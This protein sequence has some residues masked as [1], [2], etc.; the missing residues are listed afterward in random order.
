MSISYLIKHNTAAPA[1]L[2]ASGIGVALLTIKANGLDT[3]ALTVNS[4]S[5]GGAAAFAFG[6]TIAVLKRS[7][8]YP[9]TAD[10]CI[11]VGTVEEIPRQAIGGAEQTLSYVVYGPTYA[12]QR[13]HFSQQWTYRTAEGVSTKAYE[14]TVCLGE[15]NA[16][17][18]IASGPQIEQAIDYAIAVGVPIL[19]GTIAAGVTVPFDERQ[20]ITCWDAIVSML[21][22]TPD[23]VFTWDYNTTDGGVYTPSATLSAPASMS[24]VTKAVTSLS[25]GSLVPRYDIQV[26][27]ITIIFNYTDTIDGVTSKTRVTQ[28]AGTTD[29]PRSL[30]LAYDLEGYNITYLKQDVEVEDYPADWTAAAG[31]TWLKAQ[32]PWLATLADGDWTVTSCTG[33]GASGHPARL[34]S[35]SVADWM[36]VDQEPE[37]FT[38]LISYTKKDDSSGVVEQA[39]KKV[40]FQCISTDAVTKTYR[41]QGDFLGPEPV[42][43]DLASSLYTSWS[44]LHWDGSISYREQTCSADL[45]PGMLLRISGSLAAWASMDA[46]VQDTTLDLYTGT[47]SVRCGTCDRLEADNLMAIFRAARG[48]SFCFRRESR[49]EPDSSSGDI[50]GTGST[51]K[52][53]TTDGSPAERINRLRIVAQDVNADTQTIDL[54]PAAVLFEA[55]ADQAAQTIAPRERV[56]PYMDEGVLKSK[57]AQ[58]LCSEGYGA[59]IPVAGTRPADPSSP[60]TRGANTETDFTSSAAYNPLSPGAGEDGLSL[61]VSMGCFYDHTASPPL[62]KE[63]RVKLTFPNAICPAV[64]AAAAI[65]IEAPELES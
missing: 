25:S 2:A 32:V 36:S 21:R 31:K 26:P 6:D 56:V 48:R 16:G 63:F 61:W 15:S 18:R 1:T 7:S 47:T 52:S 11:F 45:L 42:P 55:E 41:K 29:N 20:N 51:P 65:T 54:Y 43:A 34:I 28:T 60:A 38:A 14:P 17:V 44:R 39:Q 64:T 33:D 30:F 49:D 40:Q 9:A 57:L 4:A 13:C 53:D 23:Y 8:D 35:G 62:L 10:V 37:T 24:A 12:L 3:L 50:P 5:F 46:V 22:Y 58:V 59:E 27:G 19:K